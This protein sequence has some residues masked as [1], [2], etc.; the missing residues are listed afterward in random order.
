MQARRK[1]FPVSD[2]AV[3]WRLTML[4]LLDYFFIFENNGLDD[5]GFVTYPHLP[6]RAT[7]ASSK[8]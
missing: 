5:L 1:Y 3:E 4:I 7:R 6:G 2:Q 8:K